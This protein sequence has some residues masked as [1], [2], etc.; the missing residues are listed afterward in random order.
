M[1]SLL[2]QALPDSPLQPNSWTDLGALTF[3]GSLLV[4]L[5]TVGFPKLMD[6]HEAAM[7]KTVDRFDAVITKLDVTRATAAREGHEAAKQLST[8]IDHSSDCVKDN[9]RAVESLTKLVVVS[10]NNQ[11]PIT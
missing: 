6:K 7:E 2:A 5:I 3:L 1:F 4:W 9:T 11:R 8:A 10:T